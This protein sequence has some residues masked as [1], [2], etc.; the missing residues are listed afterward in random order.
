M[1]WL[2]PRWHL[3]VDRFLA[4]ELHGLVK[5][6][7]AHL[8]T[9]GAH[10]A[11]R[12]GDARG[13]GP[14][15]ESGWEARGEGRRSVDARAE[16]RWMR[17]PSSWAPTR[18]SG[19]EAR[20][21]G[22]V[23]SRKVWGEHTCPP[24]GRAFSPDGEG[25]GVPPSESL[26]STASS[27]GWFATG[28]APPPP[29]E[30]PPPGYCAMESSKSSKSSSRPPTGAPRSAGESSALLNW[31]D[32][33]PSSSAPPYILPSKSSRV[34]PSRRQLSGWRPRL[35]S[36]KP[37][38]PVGRSAAPDPG[39]PPHE[40]VRGRE[41]ASQEQANQVALANA[42]RQSNNLSARSHACPAARRAPRGSLVSKVK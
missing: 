17:E 25:T 36:P 15:R 1:E 22:C 33:E 3:A 23:C 14:V 32:S 12:A 28:L 2:R 4:R 10:G 27:N 20:E 42:R 11:L 41:G 31:L 9:G 35:G 5:R 39:P 8:R 40:T 26:S 30:P 18:G 6:L 29:A 38:E 7:V 34:L 37:R 19:T 21:A 13:A 24:A 16:G